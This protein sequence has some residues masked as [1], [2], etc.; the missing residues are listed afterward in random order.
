MLNKRGNSERVLIPII[1]IIALI[2]FN[3]TKSAKAGGVF[4]RC[5]ELIMANINLT[6]NC[7]EIARLERWYSYVTGFKPGSASPPFLEARFTSKVP[8]LF[9][10]SFNFGN[11]ILL[12]KTKRNLR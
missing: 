4:G 5:T 2:G 12:P 10:I 8:G 9:R 1:S 7:A 6:N 11:L 3:P